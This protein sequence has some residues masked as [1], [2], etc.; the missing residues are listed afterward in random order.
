VKNNRKK[1]EGANLSFIMTEN[2]MIFYTT[3][4]DV[5]NTFVVSVIMAVIVITLFVYFGMTFMEGML[6]GMVFVLILN[7][8]TPRLNQ[9]TM[10]KTF[11]SREWMID[12]FMH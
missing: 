12:K 2:T 9:Y 4:L 5:P 6:F 8:F 11:A 3:E 10:P 1:Q 7:S